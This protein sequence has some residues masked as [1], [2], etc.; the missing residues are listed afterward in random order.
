MARA[1][2]RDAFFCH[3]KISSLKS[4]AKIQVKLDIKQWCAVALIEVIV[5]PEG[6]YT[7]KSTKGDD[8]RGRDT[9]SAEN[10]CVLWI[11]LSSYWREAHHVNIFENV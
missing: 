1:C 5:S 11:W 2:L 6:N 9:L 3:L 10:D 7:E 8:L 4:W